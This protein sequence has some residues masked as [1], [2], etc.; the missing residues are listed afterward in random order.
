MEYYYDI[1]CQHFYNT[2]EIHNVKKIK[3]GFLYTNWRQIY[4]KDIW[5]KK[6]WDHEIIKTMCFVAVDK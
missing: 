5:A 4:K 1:F 3:L 2:L 6:Q